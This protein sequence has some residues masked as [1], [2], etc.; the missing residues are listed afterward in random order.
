MYNDNFLKAYLTRQYSSLGEEFNKYLQDEEINPDSL[1][2]F[3]GVDALRDYLI[4]RDISKLRT[5]K[6]K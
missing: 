2:D 5:L 4:T 3:I 6:N 1:L